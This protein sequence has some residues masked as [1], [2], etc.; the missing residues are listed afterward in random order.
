MS[1][2]NI[3]YA[4]ISSSQ[5]DYLSN[6]IITKNKIKCV[7]F[8]ETKKGTSTTFHDWDELRFDGNIVNTN[9]SGG[10]LV[11]VHPSLKMVKANVSR[12]KNPLNSAVHFNVLSN[13]YL[14]IFLVHF[15]A[16][17]CIEETVF[18]MVALY[19][20]SIIIVNFNV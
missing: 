7:L 5:K 13:D 19:K 8:V 10:S 9:T 16:S 20:Y 3:L 1:T 6:N 2:L 12:I 14:H 17:A 18:T 4:N 15:H 11:Q